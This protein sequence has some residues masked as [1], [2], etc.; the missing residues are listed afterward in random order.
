MGKFNKKEIFEKLDDLF[1]QLDKKDRIM[2]IENAIKKHDI[3]D[4][5]EVRHHLNFK[6]HNKIPQYINKEQIDRFLNSD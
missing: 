1:A 4:V 3:F 6:K 5:A 2:F